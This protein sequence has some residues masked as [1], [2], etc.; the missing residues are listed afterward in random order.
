MGYKGWI[1]AAVLLCVGCKTNDIDRGGDIGRWASPTNTRLIYLYD[2]ILYKFE[3]HNRCGSRRYTRMKP[4]DWEYDR[5]LNKISDGNPFAVWCY[6]DATY[7]Y[8]NPYNIVLCDSNER[9]H[10]E[11]ICYFY[12][13]DQYT[14]RETI[15]E[16]LEEQNEDSTN[17]GN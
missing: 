15:K 1:I 7:D 9:S 16:Y 11:L 6:R 14:K 8:I 3:D 10:L 4:G 12:L 2:D 13:K 5:L 17:H